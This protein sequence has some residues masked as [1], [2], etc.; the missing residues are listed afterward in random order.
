VN[1]LTKRYAIKI[2]WNS[3]LILCA[4]GL[5]FLSV[6]LFRPWPFSLLSKNTALA[7]GVGSGLAGYAL[8]VW[9]GKKANKAGQ[10][11]GVVVLV[12]V[13][14]GGLGLVFLN[15]ELAPTR[16][17]RLELEI[18]MPAGSSNSSQIRGLFL[19]D[20]YLDVNSYCSLVS[21]GQSQGMA[22]TWVT[23]AAGDRLTCQLFPRLLD[24]LK[25]TWAGN[26]PAIEAR[27]FIDEVLGLSQ[28]FQPG[29]PAAGFIKVG[30]RLVPIHLAAYANAW[31]A[32]AGVSVLA[33]LLLL[34]PLAVFRDTLFGRLERVLQTCPSSLPAA[35]LLVSML[36][37]GSAAF[38]HSGSVNLAQAKMDYYWNYKVFNPYRY[39]MVLLGSSRVFVGVSPREMMVLLPDMHIYNFGFSSG[40]LTPR[41][42]RFA[43]NHLDSNSWK[44]AANRM[45][46]S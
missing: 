29:D 9:A 1:L 15:P 25:V 34:I 5:C 32:L 35:M 28:K 16:L 37:I 33:L 4:A 17:T 46:R 42:Y 18:S 44:F 31:L 38:L 12:S 22:Q 23:L 39:D 14:L 10:P 11:L 20:R 8:A 36:V 21:N 30:L 3:A 13:Y 41:M 19:D 6:Y 26:T 43:E 45:T 2:L 24:S 7:A 40:N 27:S